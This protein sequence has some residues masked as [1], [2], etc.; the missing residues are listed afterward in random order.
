MLDT[1]ERLFHFVTQSTVA[2]ISGDKANFPIWDRLEDF[3]AFG[4]D[5]PGRRWGAF[6][7]GELK[8]YNPVWK[9]VLSFVDVEQEPRYTH[10]PNVEPDLTYKFFAVMGI[11]DLW[12]VYAYIEGS[13]EPVKKYLT[14][15]EIPEIDHGLDA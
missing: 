12:V 14:F 3:L 10:V 11:R 8:R 15:M 13:E 6:S 4:D 5:N 1:F 9:K 7:E 2:A